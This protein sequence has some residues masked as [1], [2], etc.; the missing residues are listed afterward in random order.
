MND[1]EFNAVI[2]DPRSRAARYKE[3]LPAY[4]ERVTDTYRKSWGESF[5]FAVFKGS[6]PLDEAL[7]ATEHFVAD[8]GGFKPG[9]RVLDVGCG[10][11][12]PALNIAEHSGAHVTGLNIVEYQLRI[13]R[14]RARDRGLA[15]RTH[16]QHGDAM[17]LPFADATFDAVYIFEAACHM[18]DKARFYAECARVL[19]PGGPFLGFEWLQRDAITPEE[20]ARWIEPVCRL[21]SVPALGS[22]S[23]TRCWMEAAGL[24]VEVVESANAYGN[25]LR[26]WELLDEKTIAGIRGLPS[27]GIDPVLRMLTDGGIVLAEAARAGVFIIGHFMARKPPLAG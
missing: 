11:G 24:T 1:A 19:M 5:H 3:M 22:P 15:E 21:H 12:G 2:A 10:V 27:E 7:A 8:R 23:E 26:N 14:Q 25:F 6:E 13:A 4:Y 20:Q 9:M 17:A 16:F 18:P